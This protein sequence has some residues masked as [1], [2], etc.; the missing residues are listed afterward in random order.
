MKKNVLIKNILVIV[1]ITFLLLGFT[2]CS[3]TT[4][5]TPNTGTVYI[6][7]TG[8]WSSGT[9]DIYMDGFYLGTTSTASYVIPNVTPG[10]HIFEAGQNIPG[11]TYDSETV[12]I[13]VGSNYISLSPLMIIIMI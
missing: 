4:P 3:L 2:G 11:S 12:Y 8:F 6:T 5:P 13:N 1:V 10:T 7:I 9:H